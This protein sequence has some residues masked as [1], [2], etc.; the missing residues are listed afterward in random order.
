MATQDKR[1]WRHRRAMAWIAFLGSIA[2]PF[3]MYFLKI[4]EIAVIPFYSFTTVVVSE[5]IIG[6]VFDDNNMKHV[7][8]SENNS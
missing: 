7:N 6:S 1:R 2:F 5:Y 8:R 4:P 3:V